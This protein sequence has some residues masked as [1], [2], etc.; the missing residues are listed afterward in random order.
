MTV[1][2]ESLLPRLER[3]AGAGRVT[4]DAE[5]LAQYEADG[6]RPLAAVQPASPDELVEIVRFAAAEGLALLP[7]GSGT[8]LSQGMPPRRYDLAVDL[9]R[10]HRVLAYDAGDLTLSVEAGARLGDVARMLEQQR[11]FLPLSVPFAAQATLGGILATNSSG[12]LR[13]L[14]GTARDFVIGMEF[15]TGEGRRAKSGGRVV[16]N[17]AGYDLHK[18]MI[19]ALGTLGIITAANFKTFP[20]PQATGAWT[21]VFPEGEGALGFRAAVAHSRLA[22]RTFDL[23]CPEA[24][25]LLDARAGGSRVPP[26]GAWTALVSAGGSE[27]AVKRHGRELERLAGEA[28]AGGFTELAAEESAPL[29]ERLREFSSAI[30]QASPAA[31]LVKFSVLPGQFPA[32]LDRAGAIA[33][34]HEL[35]SARIVRAAGLVYWALLPDPGQA[36]ERLAAAATEFFDAARQAGGCAVV[37]RCPSELKRHVNVWGPAGED[38]KLMQ[39]LKAVF[40]PQGILAPGRY[41]GG[42]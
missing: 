28:G 5:T 36:I 33:E 24:A 21:A 39:K 30:R 14:Y 41:Y 29:W 13:Q 11:Q 10:L 20:L 9:A 26:A 7:V 3:I 40:D 15:V 23:A 8:K 12:P 4:A 31:T 6:A 16:K 37:E 2:R 38:A 27:R 18:L 19:G 35:R 17:V 25:R 32:L 42:I 34:R 1:A 22:P